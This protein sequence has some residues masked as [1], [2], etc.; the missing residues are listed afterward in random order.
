MPPPD[1][2]TH[3]F[4]PRVYPP[5]CERRMTWVFLGSVNYSVTD[6]VAELATELCTTRAGSVARDDEGTIWN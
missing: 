5:A 3:S 2:F 4:K 6:K 1:S